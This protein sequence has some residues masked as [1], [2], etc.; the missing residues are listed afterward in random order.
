MH[1]VIAD[2]YQNCVKD[3]QCFSILKDHQTTLRLNLS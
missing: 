2:D 1:V 3:L